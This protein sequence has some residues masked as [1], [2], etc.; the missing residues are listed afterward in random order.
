MKR[1]VIDRPTSPSPATTVVTGC[2]RN[3]VSAIDTSA[4]MVKEAAGKEVDVARATGGGKD[5]GKGLSFGWSALEGTHRY[6]DD[7]PTDGQ[8]DPIHHAPR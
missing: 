8:T 3:T 7:Q 1:A 2:S 6:N 4:G 5:A